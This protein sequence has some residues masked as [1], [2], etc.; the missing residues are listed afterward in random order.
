MPGAT[1]AI[2]EA[3]HALTAKVFAKLNDTLNDLQAHLQRWHV[4]ALDANPIFSC[5]LLR[6]PQPFVL[7]DGVESPNDYPARL[8]IMQLP[9][10]QIYNFHFQFKQAM[11]WRGHLR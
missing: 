6:V 2:D 10:L 1:V 5:C 9:T 7:L 4:L 8:N 11:A 3:R